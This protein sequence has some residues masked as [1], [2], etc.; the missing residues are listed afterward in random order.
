MIS[1]SSLIPESNFL[2]N[3]DDFYI[4]IDQSNNLMFALDLHVEASSSSQFNH[5]D[6]PQD[7]P[8]YIDKPASVTLASNMP[9]APSLPLGSTFLTRDSILGIFLHV[10]AYYQQ[11]QQPP[12]SPTSQ[13]QIRSG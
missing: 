12:P 1:T 9:K 2:P 7:S 4:V 6:T 3:M 10:C 13:Q 8:K 11:S 5:L